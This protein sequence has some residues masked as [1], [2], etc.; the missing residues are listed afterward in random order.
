MTFILKIQESFRKENQNAL[1]ETEINSGKDGKLN[2]LR[3]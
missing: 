3:Y 2:D 1:E